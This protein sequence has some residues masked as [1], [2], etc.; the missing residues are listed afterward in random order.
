VRIGLDLDGVVVD[1]IGRWIEVLNRKA[2]PKY[3]L[4]AL[5]DTS[6]DPELNANIH[7]SHDC[8]HRG[9]FS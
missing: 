3:T 5:P 7:Q 8:G 1:S 2:G 9:M 6:A 4:D